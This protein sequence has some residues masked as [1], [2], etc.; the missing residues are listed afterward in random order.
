MYI[1]VRSFARHSGY[2][3]YWD[4]RELAMH[5]AS[6]YLSVLPLLV[7]AGYSRRQCGWQCGHR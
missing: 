6:V 4:Y 3:R 2:N 7:Y 5:K 1:S